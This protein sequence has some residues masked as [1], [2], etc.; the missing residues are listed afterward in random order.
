MKNLY[1]AALLLSCTAAFAQNTV[2]STRHTMTAAEYAEFMKNAPKVTDMNYYDT[3]GHIVDSVKAKAMVKSFDYEK[4]QEKPAG[5]T[6]YKYVLHKVN[7]AMQEKR[8]ARDADYF[9]PKSSK[10]TK[11]ATLDLTALAKHTDI[12]KLDGKAI[13]MLFYI[14]TTGYKSMYDEINDAVSNNIDNNKFEVLAITRLDYKGAKN[15]QKEVPI[16]NAHHIVDAEDLTNFYETEGI[17]VT[18]VTNQQHQIIYAAQNAPAMTPR[19][20]NRLLKA[21]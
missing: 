11:G 18:V 20:L 1:T 3:E 13:V 16:L 21:L 14:N 2:V 6:E 10:L 19:T 9:W 12:K 5:A 15:L 7:Q 4:W 8:D 17:A